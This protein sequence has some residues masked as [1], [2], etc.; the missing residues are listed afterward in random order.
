MC[1]HAVAVATGA[2]AS[3]DFKYLQ[4]A[5]LHFGAT[6]L[7]VRLGRLL[8]VCR[9]TDAGREAALTVVAHDC[10]HLPGPA[11]QTLATPAATG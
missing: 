9:D 4:K 5:G 6:Q 8:P 2:L 11:L 10:R 1:I 3:D 7:V